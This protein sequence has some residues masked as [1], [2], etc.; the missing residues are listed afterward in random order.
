MSERCRYRVGIDVGLYSVGLAAIEID[1]SSD[2]PLEALPMRALSIKSVIHDG[3]LDPQVGQQSADSRKSISGIARRTRRLHDRRRERYEA[4]NGLLREYG[5]PCDQAIMMVSAMEHGDP[6]LPWRARIDLAERYEENDQQRRLALSIAIRHIARHRGWRNPYA[7]V[8]SVIDQSPTASKFYMEFFEKVQWWRYEQGLDLYPGVS[9]SVADDGSKALTGVPAWDEEGQGTD[10]PTPAELIEPFLSPLPQNRF[11]RAPKEGNAETATL[12][13]G[14]LHQSDN[15]Y[16]LL[17]IFEMQRV[18]EDQQRAILDAVFHQV[19]P[20][21]VGAA[22]QLVGTDDLPGQKRRQRALRSSLEFQRYRILST[23]ANLRVRKDGTERPLG[24]MERRGLYEYL[25]SNEAAKVGK[26][27]TWNDVAEVLGIKRRSLAGVGGQTADGIPISAQRPPYLETEEIIRK[28]KIYKDKRLRRLRDWWEDEATP[29]EKEFLIAFFDNAGVS[30]KTLDANEQQAKAN[31]DVI[32]TE[33]ATLEEDALDSLDKIRLASGRAA[34]SLDSLRRLNNRMLEDGLDLHEA[35]KAEFGVGD[36][37]HPAPEALGT[38]TGNP[39]VDR[40]IKIVSQWLQACKRRWGAPETIAIEHVREGFKSERQKREDTRDMNTRQRANDKV[41]NEIVEALGE[42]AGSQARGAESIRRS[43]IR[44]WQAIQRQNNEC[45]YCGRP[46]TF[47]TAQM[48]HIVPRKGPGSSNDLPNLVATCADCNKSKSNTL[49][50]SWATPDKREEAIERVEHWTRDSYFKSDKQFRN[51][52]KDVISRLEQKEEDD[53]LDNRSMES[54]AW[55]ALELRDQIAGYFEGDWMAN[56]Q[57]GDMDISQRVMVYRGWLTAEAR[58]ASGIE[59]QLPWIGD[60]KAKTRL[61]RRH[62]AVDASVIAFMRPG[63][64]KTLIEREALRREQLDLGLDRGAG[65][66]GDFRDWVGSG[67]SD[68]ELY[69]HWRDEQMACLQKVLSD[70]MNEDRVI[71]TQPLR[72]RLGIGRAH[73][74]TINPMLKKRVGDSLSVSAIDKA[75]TPAL[76]VALTRQPD[77]DPKTGLPE[78]PDRRIRVQDRWLSADDTI[79]F[80]A[81][82]EDE[83]NRTIS[84]V[85]AKVRN[86]YVEIGDTIHHARFYRIPKLNRKGEQTGWSYA[87]LRVFQIDLLRHGKDDLFKV[88]LPPQSISVRNASPYL[89]KALVEDSADYLGWMVTGDE[90]LVDQT[91]KLFSETGNGKINLFM[92]AFP[93]TRRFIVTG[94][95]DNSRLCI[96][97]RYMASEGILDLDSDRQGEYAKDLLRRTYGNHDWSRAEIA[98]INTV[99]SLRCYLSVDKVLSTHPS[100][101]RRNVLGEERWSSSN[102]MPTSWKVP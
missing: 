21:D 24:D 30:E 39:A 12:Q 78:N 58:R 46:I 62:H 65:T 16:E 9:I 73:K 79:G 15:C 102:H 96:R 82:T 11:R 13:I 10:R 14:K 70:A 87:M 55:M 69:L 54:V 83:L 44:K 74:D 7:T 17:K 27:L 38:P 93:S 4:I 64:A 6:Y 41:R 101:I 97:P 32:L 98:T 22:A 81:A 23:I 8:K 5:Y 75:E 57:P 68:T 72:L 60:Y 61:D 19:S 67:K 94:F 89:R 85:R 20:K 53:P 80:M 90:L 34:Y 2:D 49:F 71:V 36:G 99:I 40:T 3:A 95:V 25:T 66:Y 77:F 92:R 29:L 45:L 50:W 43:D 48:D 91:S 88:A 1:D 18:P 76:W 52:K 59:G 37:W 35:R 63:V 26:D 100:I 56:P 84:A 33:L 86:G 47:Q 42:A 28:S 51:F 31:V